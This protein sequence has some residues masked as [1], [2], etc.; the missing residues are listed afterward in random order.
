MYFGWQN[1]DGSEHI[2]QYEMNLHSSD[3]R[4]PWKY[5][6][7]R[8]RRGNPIRILLIIFFLSTQPNVHVEIVTK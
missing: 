2:E 3:L 8:D 4:I 7:R 5:F 6:L 1:D